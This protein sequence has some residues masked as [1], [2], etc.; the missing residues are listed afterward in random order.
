MESR[1]K[2]RIFSNFCG[3]KIREN[4]E[5]HDNVNFRDRISRSRLVKLPPARMY[6]E[7]VD[8]AKL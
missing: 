2:Y 6:L 4:V 7:D 8:D 3:P 1:A 5:N